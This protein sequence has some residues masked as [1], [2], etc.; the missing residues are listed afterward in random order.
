MK[1][2]TES[3]WDYPRPPRIDPDDRN[4]RVAHRGIVVAESKTAQRV[5]ETSHPPAFYLP[6]H[7]V[8]T[9]LLKRGS[10]TS[11]CE[12]KGGGEV[13]EPHRWR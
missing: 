6:P 4:V 7:D 8:R 2:P 11:V 12:W 5:L 1:R 9:D 10:G 3:V 13:L